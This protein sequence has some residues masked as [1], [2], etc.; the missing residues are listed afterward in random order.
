MNLLGLPFSPLSRAEHRHGGRDPRA[1]LS[2]RSEFP[3]APFKKPDTETSI[4][5]S[6]KAQAK[7]RR[8]A[9]D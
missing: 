1:D 2:E 6:G 3:R 7:A 5:P 4:M 9:I 8:A